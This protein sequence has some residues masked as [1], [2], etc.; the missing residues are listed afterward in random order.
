MAEGQ[1]ESLTKAYDTIGSTALADIGAE[2]N[3]VMFQKGK[4]NIWSVLT[5]VSVVVAPLLFLIFAL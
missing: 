1:R 2:N 3:S 4:F 5:D